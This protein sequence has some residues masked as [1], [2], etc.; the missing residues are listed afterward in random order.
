MINQ[1]VDDATKGYPYSPTNIGR[2]PYVIYQ[3]FTGIEAIVPIRNMKVNTIPLGRYPPG[4][5]PIPGG[6]NH[7]PNHPGVLPRKD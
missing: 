3:F 2:I 5:Q 7:F 1:E 4:V 6:I